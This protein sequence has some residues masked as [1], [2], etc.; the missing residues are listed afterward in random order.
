MSEF[1]RKA[2]LGSLT[3]AAGSLGGFAGRFVINAIIARHLDAVDFGQ[4]ALAMVSAEFLG[5]LGAFSFPQ[6]L[7]QLDD[8]H[9]HIV[10][11][12]LWMSVA[13]ALG[14][15]VVALGVWPFV[16]AAYGPVVG[17]C[18]VAMAGS[19]LTVGIGDTLVAAQ[20]R[21]YAYHSAALVQ[22]IGVIVAAVAALTLALVDPSPWALVVRDVGPQLVVTLV[23]GSWLLRRE[24]RALF[25]FSRSTAREVWG[26]SKALFLNRA[27][28]IAYLRVDSLVIGTALGDRELGFYQQARYLA[29][30]PSAVVAPISGVVGL[31]TMSALHDDPRR[32]GRVFQLTQFAITR[33]LIVFAIGAAVGGDFATRVI[34]GPGWE[35][36]G[37]LLALFAP[38]LVVLPVAQNYKVMLIAIR[39]FPPIFWATGVSAAVMGACALPLALWLDSEGMVLGNLVAV[40]AYLWIKVAATPPHLAV[41]ASTYVPTALAG[42]GAVAA[43]WGARLLLREVLPGWWPVV[44]GLAAGYLVFLALSWL[45]ERNRLKAELDYVL[46]IIRSRRQKM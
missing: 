38:W 39:K 40:N 20:Q 37:H 1:G 42:A 16:S 45:L 29:G 15:F 3:T 2:L 31:R 10:G 8:G 28:E 9:E 13:L 24:G 17:A 32:Q 41:S 23:L 25:V 30:L 11:T 4:F 46:G 26:L 19:R 5:I 43:G 12:V 14:L 33:L 18:F 7:L 21:R 6:T 44:V 36:T 27:L 35:R 22:L 34:F